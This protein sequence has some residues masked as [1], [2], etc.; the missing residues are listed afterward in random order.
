MAGVEF[1]FSFVFWVFTVLS[2]SLESLHGFESEWE[3]WTSVLE[4][5]IYRW[6]SVSC[7]MHSEKNS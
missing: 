7:V 4:V 6:I 1:A 3:T 5:D 2:K